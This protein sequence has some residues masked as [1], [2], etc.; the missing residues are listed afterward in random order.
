VT[1]IVD[2]LSTLY[3]I[4]IDTSLALIERPEEAYLTKQS[5]FDGETCEFTRNRDYF[6]YW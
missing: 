5:F 1:Y 6:A 4:S 3:I 2:L